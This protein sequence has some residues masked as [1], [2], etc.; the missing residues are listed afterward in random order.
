MVP[1]RTGDVLL[2]PL[3]LV[4]GLAQLAVEVGFVADDVV[5]SDG[6]GDDALAAKVAELAGG[7]LGEG[8]FE[9]VRGPVDDRAFWRLA[10]IWRSVVMTVASLGCWLPAGVVGGGASV[11]ALTPQPPPLRGANIGCAD[12]PVR[13][14]GGVNGG[15]AGRAGTWRPLVGARG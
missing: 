9:G 7:A 8:R 5:E 15:R 14:R 2:E 12:V 10:A 3:D 13:G 4:E 6:L 11:E 1:G